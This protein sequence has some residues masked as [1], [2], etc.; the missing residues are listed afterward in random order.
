MFD[1]KDKLAKEK[2]LRALKRENRRR[3]GLLLV[4]ALQITSLVVCYYLGR[5]SKRKK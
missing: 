4:A 1:E 3:D 5:S 2:E